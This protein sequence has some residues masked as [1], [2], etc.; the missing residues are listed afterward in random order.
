[1]V[2]LSAAV[3]DSE[4]RLFEI[5]F[6]STAENLF[7]DRWEQFAI[8]MRWAGGFSVTDGYGVIILTF[9]NALRAGWW[10]VAGCGLAC[11]SGILRQNKAPWV[12][13][14]LPPVRKG[15]KTEPAGVTT[16]TT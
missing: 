5:L 1:M 7:S 12:C 16:I 13:F 9:Y 8:S 3:R 15:R 6:V 14:L 11:G 10:G 2:R 4:L